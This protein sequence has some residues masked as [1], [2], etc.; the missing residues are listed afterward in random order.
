[1]LG[2]REPEIYGNMTLDQLNERVDREAA[3][4]GI[5]T[6]FY[7]SNHEG[8]IIDKIQESYGKID[9]LIINPGA[10]THYSYAIRDALASVD[11]PAV[12]VHLSDITMREYFRRTSVIEDVAARQIYGKGVDSYIEAVHYFYGKSKHEGR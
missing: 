7:Q 6:E 10:F 8:S 9:G 5:E 2:I 4:L 3:S 11:Y 1:M 12:E